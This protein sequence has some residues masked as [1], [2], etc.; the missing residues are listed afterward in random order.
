MNSKEAGGKPKMLKTGSF[1]ANLLI[2]AGLD[3]MGLASGK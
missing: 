2:Y 1:S 3:I